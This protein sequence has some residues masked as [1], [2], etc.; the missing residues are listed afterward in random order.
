MTRRKTNSR[1]PETRDV[2]EVL[3]NS[4]KRQTNKCT[5]VAATRPRRCGG[6]HSAFK[7]ITICGL[8]QIPARRAPLGGFDSSPCRMR[9][10]NSCR[11]AARG[12][13]LRPAVTFRRGLATDAARI[14]L[15]DYLYTKV[16]SRTRYTSVQFLLNTCII[17]V[18]RMRRCLGRQCVYS[19]STFANESSLASIDRVV[20]K[21]S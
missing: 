5:Y 12:V 14:Q 20:S 7:S 2:E 3:S 9:R 6:S 19:T 13:V 1:A 4:P 17:A 11:S 18:G 15:G 21:S 16:P 10:R 8:K